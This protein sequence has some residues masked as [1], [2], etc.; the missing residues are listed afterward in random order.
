M[1]KV[2]LSVD[3][4]IEKSIENRLMQE[5]PATV[6]VLGAAVPNCVLN[7]IEQ[8]NEASLEHV[9]YENLHESVYGLHR[10]DFALVYGVLE[11]ISRDDGIQLISRLRDFHSKLLWVLVPAAGSDC[12]GPQDAVANGMRLAS[13]EQFSTDKQQMYEFSLKFYKPAP[14]WLNA[15]DWANPERW[16]KFRW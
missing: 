6:L 11:T 2:D 4:A 8:N 12:Y 5:N 7:Y 13:P 16:N 9:V 3:S 15:K 10:F 1:P 14:Q